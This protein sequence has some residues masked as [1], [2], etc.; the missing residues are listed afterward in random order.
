MMTKHGNNSFTRSTV[1]NGEEFRDNVTNP[2]LVREQKIKNYNPPN[3]EKVAKMLP[4]KSLVL[5][6]EPITENEKG[7]V[8]RHLSNGVVCCR[9]NA[10]YNFTW[11]IN[12]KL[13]M[14]R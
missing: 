13:S 7:P 1:Y 2:A 14:F 4:P 8:T 3:S 10:L 12:S 6:K 9:F 5:Q 11:I